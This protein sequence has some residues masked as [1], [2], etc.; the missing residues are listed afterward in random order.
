MF[1]RM[2]EHNTL[3]NYT[4]WKSDTARK[5]S[6]NVCTIRAKAILK[7]DGITKTTNVLVADALVTP[8]PIVEPRLTLG[9]N[10]LETEEEVQ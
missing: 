6:P 2:I 10:V 1:D 3:T 4:V 5:S 9:E 8:E 7:V